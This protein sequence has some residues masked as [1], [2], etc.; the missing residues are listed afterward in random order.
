MVTASARTAGWIA[1]LVALCVAIPATAHAQW[2]RVDSPNFVVIGDVGAGTLRDVAVQFEGFRETLGRVLR[3]RATETAVP[4]VVIAFPHDRAFTPFKP[5]FQG[6]PIELAG[7]FLARRDINYI[8]II[9]DGRP[10]RLRTVFHEFVHLVV[11][12][13]G[14]R[15]PV[16]L[17]EGLAEHYSTY[18]VYRDGREAIIG[19]AI[20]S[21]LAQLNASP[22][23]PLER[24]LTTEHS[25]PLYNEGNRRSLFYAQSWAL[26][27]LLLLGGPDR[28]ANLSAYLDQLLSGKTPTEAWQSAFAGQDVQR[29]LEIYVRQQAFK[30]YR[31][32]F[33]E[34][35]ATF[36]GKP[37][38]MPAADVQAL[39]ADFLLQQGRLDEAAARLAAAPAA[40]R[41]PLMDVVAAHL[42]IAKGDSDAADA[43]LRGANA[44]ADWFAAYR[45][46]VAIAEVS[47]ARGS[48]T[49]AAH[50]ENAR[51]HFDAA[52]AGRTVLP[53]AV[54]RLA[55]LELRSAAGP[56]AETKAAIERA[57]ALVPGRHELGLLQAQ[58]LAE[59]SEFAAA[60]TAL[61]PLLSTQY[62]VHVRDA[63]RSLMGYVVTLESAKARAERRESDPAPGGATPLSAATLAAAAGIPSTPAPTSTELPPADPV[64][65]PVFRELKPGEQLIQGT[66]AGIECARDGRPAF[67]VKTSDEVVTFFAS[68]LDDVDFIT[69][70]NDLTGGVNCG[71]FKEP[72][73]VYLTW[74][75]ATDGSAVKVVV[76]VEFLPR[77]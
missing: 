72:M 21:H 7:L 24:L 44:V 43:R 58:I 23:L 61:G 62:P 53:N 77:R 16:W 50:L 26:T 10:E 39:L 63:A 17:N 73:A 51:R 42:A 4:T 40:A 57:R 56:S 15:V 75:P 6:K 27:H 66:L 30:R 52:A 49:D 70:R 68:K 22:L 69:Y 71:R 35:L 74:R 76:A 65:V 29:E 38:T 18:E 36:D 54:A 67:D 33:S 31:F 64:R 13:G 34:K 46:G 14:R 5:R 37:T 20:E 9:T 47:D 11:S 8:A 60:R 12:N 25:S 48:R 45:T 28:T 1:L 3:E 2:R 41:N 55:Q 59:L 19:A 32:R